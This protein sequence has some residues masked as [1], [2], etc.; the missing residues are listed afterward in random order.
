MKTLLILFIL[1]ILHPTYLFA[2]EPLSAIDW[3]SKSSRPDI[4]QSFG[5]HIS[6]KS[7]QTPKGIV[8][9][10]Q[11]GL[12]SLNSLGII[13]AETLELPKTIWED[14]EESKLI[15]LLQNFPKIKF[16][17]GNIFL[18]KL[19]IAEASPPRM[20]NT[21]SEFLEQRLNNL[22]ELGALEEV[23]NILKLANPNSKEL[24][25]I[26]KDSALLSG[27]IE[28][29]CE[30]I[31]LSPN[32]RIEE[33]V[34]ILCLANRNE[35]ETAAFVLNSRMVLESLDPIHQE[36]L[37]LYL[38]PDFNTNINFEEKEIHSPLT[39][40]LSEVLSIKFRE[41][42]LPIKYYFSD[43]NNG[44]N[45][46]RRLTAK[47]EYIKSGLIP[48]SQILVELR[49]LYYEQ[50]NLH[51]SEL[52]S[53]IDDLILED[54]STSAESLQQLFLSLSFKF[55]EP[56][57][58]IPYLK[59]FSKKI[60]NSYRKKPLKKAY[61]IFSLSFLL[62]DSWFPI[63]LKGANRYP[64]LLFAKN[65]KSRNLTEEIIEKEKNCD[66][67]CLSI[68]K[69]MLQTQNDEYK[70]RNPP[71]N[72]K[73]GEKLLMALTL[74]ANGEKSSPENVAKGLS[75]MIEAGQRK[76]AE[77]FS[78]EL[79]VRRYLN[80]KDLEAIGVQKMIE[81]LKKQKSIE[82]F[83][84]QS[85]ERKNSIDRTIKKF[86][87]VFDLKFDSINVGNRDFKIKGKI[88]TNKFSLE[89]KHDF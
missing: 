86:S 50:N 56:N 72:E 66:K 12:V 43:L 54:G 15:F 42:D 10:S 75:L 60:E 61:E 87:N 45:F 36:L 14:S 67:F 3:I 5:K 48:F 51:E 53:S 73:V 37:F 47:K 2:G 9:E 78:V 28:G 89:L 79:L 69:S 33:A 23:D 81:S 52:L 82:S 11:L 1:I 80:K 29:F 62:G 83:G 63:A 21:K 74:L 6:S 27:R 84:T 71:K 77:K 24:M 68:T 88:R 44:Y 40:Y 41:Q 58:L 30:S 19:L 13:S 4:I 59:F 65:I 46:D 31:L 70:F 49:E 26:W 64:E 7:N 8:L 16:L 55:D 85:A 32:I 34:R 38:D 76:M 39:F 35:W 22:M 25:Q 18:R 17:E 20:E 57:L